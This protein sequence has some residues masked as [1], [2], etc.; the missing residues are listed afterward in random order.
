MATDDA[1]DRVWALVG[2]ETVR[3]DDKPNV[4]G[5]LQRLCRAAA[6]AL[7]ATGVGV[8][9]MGDGG[10][11]VS[12]AASSEV[13]EEIE[14]L[15]FVLG[16]GPCLDA[17]GSGGPVLMPDLVAADRTR[18][19]GY[20]PAAQ[21][22]G[23]RAVFAFPLQVGAAR[24]GALDVYQDR[25]GPLAAPVLSQAL[26]F[27][28]VA[29]QILLDAQYDAQ[30][31]DEAESPGRTADPQGE[32]TRLVGDALGARLEVYQAQGMVMVQLGVSL[33]E[34]MSRLRAYAYAHD[35]RLNDVAADV[36]ARK[37]VLEG[38]SE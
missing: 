27:A 1:L 9:V 30:H 16:E 34:A 28:D 13:N 7:P 4:A 10:E 5:R 15:Q 33:Q 32:E 20:A 36:V 2:Q 35:R 11:Q 37:V 38:D 14:E 8:S 19:P 22:F 18:W 29:M 25:A 17:Y 3:P 31:Q 24:L 26:T 23:V 21:E 12:V 6:A